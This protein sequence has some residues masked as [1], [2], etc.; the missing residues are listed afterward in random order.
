MG[1]ARY[2]IGVQSGRE[3]T[4]L[5]LALHMQAW[6]VEPPP[7]TRGVSRIGL[8][9]SDPVEFAVTFVSLVALGHWVV[10]LDPTLANLAPP[11]LNERLGA[12]HLTSVVSDQPAPSDLGIQWRSVEPGQGRHAVQEADSGGP[13][14]GGVILSSSGTSG[15]PKVVMLASRQLLET[16]WLVARHNELAVTDVGFNPL[17]L[18]H[19]NAQVVGV[20]ATLVAGSSLVLDDRFHRTGFWTKMEHYGVTWINAVPAIIARL[21]ILRDNEA[22]PESVRF[23]RSASA[24]L[25]PALLVEFERMLKVPVIETYGMTEAASQICANPLWGPR[26]SGSV[27]KPVGVELRIRPLEVASTP[28][29]TESVVGEVEIRGSS[30]IKR[31][32]SAGLEDRFDEQ[33]W[34]KTGDQGY[35]DG[36]GYL[37]L[38][39]RTDDVINRGGEK[40][41]PRE[42]ENVVLVVNGVANAA[43]IAIADDVFGQVPA[44][45]LQVRP[46]SADDPGNR[47][48]SVLFE[49]RALLEQRFAK[50]MRPVE[51]IVVES[52]PVHA[53]GKIQKRMLTH[54]SVVV[55]KRLA[56]TW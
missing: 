52:M 1:D 4:Y 20:L 8:L 51:I 39:G 19:I 50:P 9:I 42:I 53:T 16:A 48:E 41:F 7:L 36:D 38:V 37:Y 29:G 23:I 17:P 33:G 45:Y 28:S 21:M 25:A 54:E 24:P 44:L 55:L 27:G 5:E 2:L 15:I 10:P 3:V 18:W 43:V 49:V 22:V 12:L 11:E 47:I 35:L 40:I 32:E 56:M 46:G 26:K 14:A 13:V 6:H 34:L 30:V 31:Y